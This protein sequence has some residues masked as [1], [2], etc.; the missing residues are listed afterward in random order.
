MKD[1]GI[2]R[3][4]DSMCRLVLPRELLKTRDLKPTDPVE[5]YVESDDIVIEK[6]NTQN[7]GSVRNI[8]T[9]GR[10]SRNFAH[11]RYNS[12]RCCSFFS[13]MGRE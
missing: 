13:R 2:V 4:L 1:T 6:V 10:V 11:T 3:K 7:A 12:A 5:F 8:D 9:L